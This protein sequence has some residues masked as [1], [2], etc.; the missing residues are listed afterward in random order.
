MSDKS[1]YVPFIAFR[2]RWLLSFHLKNS[3]KY[4]GFF[5]FPGWMLTL[6]LGF[7]ISNPV[8]LYASDAQKVPHLLV[9]GLD[10]I[11][12]STFKKM[13]DGGHFRNFETVSPM[14][15][16]FP[17]ISDPNWTNLFRLPPEPGFT[18]GYFD[19]TIKT[20]DGLGFES[21][22]ILTDVYKSPR[23][24]RIMDFRI[25]GVWQ[26]LSLIL[27]TKTTALYWLESLEKEFFEFKGF[28]TF[29]ALIVNTDII[30]HTDGENSVMQYL[31]V[32]DDK[33]ESIQKKY[34][35]IYGKKLEVVLVSDHGNS[36]VSPLDI[37]WVE[38]IKPLGWN[39]KATISNDKDVGFFV[40]EILGAGAFFCKYDKRMDLALALSKVNHMQS[41]MYEDDKH[42][43]HIF[44]THGLSEGVITYDEKKDL[45]NYQLKKG[46]DP[47]EQIGHFKN[48]P[49][50]SESYFKKSYSDKFPNSV[51]RVWEGFNKN[52]KIKPYV[53]ASGD[54]G[55]VFGNKALR[56]LTDIK[57][58]TSTHGALNKSDSWG[59]FVSTKRA[60]PA[61]RP[62][63]FGNFVDLHF[64]KQRDE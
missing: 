3:S 52:S 53:L 25:S 35:K 2:P 8:C 51:M 31:H 1:S 11:S 42:E 4:L 62:Q 6:S 48:G 21:G 54:Y 5:G 27:W 18:K 12:Y 13:Q 14:V 24:E 9:L 61:I 37:P 43:I 63:D 30:S 60:L 32:I 10:G 34:F 20:S 39:L 22:S 40:P 23:Y 7:V 50:H 16:S 36:F 45:L 58:F 49:Q 46:L 15:A 44:G 29:F 55:Y 59:I 38:E 26:H 64:L 41:A 28:D 57:G 47:L 56:I 17:S 19:P 33:I